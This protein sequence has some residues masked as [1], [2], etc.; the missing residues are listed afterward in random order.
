MS[1]IRNLIMAIIIIA[2]VSGASPVPQVFAESNVTI[3]LGSTKQIF[4]SEYSGSSRKWFSSNPEVVSIVDYEPNGRSCTIRGESIGKAV[5]TVFVSYNE[6]VPQWIELEDGKGYWNTGSIKNAK[7]FTYN[8]MVEE[9]GLKSVTEVHIREQQ[10]MIKGESRVF[11]AGLTPRLTSDQ[12][13]AWKSSNTKVAT[14]DASGRVKAVDEGTATITVTALKGNKSDSCLLNVTSLS[15]YT[16]IS[17]KKQLDII[18]KNPSGRFYLTKDI[19]FTD[20]DFKSGG[21]YY[22]AGKG[23]APIE[24]FTGVFNGNGHVIKNLRISASGEEEQNTG[25][26]A[27]N[28]G[29]VSNL[30]FTGGSITSKVPNSRL[31]MITGFNP[32][33]GII[34]N[35]YNTGK[36][37]SVSICGGIAGKND[38]KILDCYN[39]GSIDAN[40]NED[41]SAGGIAGSSGQGRDAWIIDC[42]NKGTIS[43][44]GIDYINVGGI[45]GKNDLSLLIRCR[46]TGSVTAQAETAHYLNQGANAGGIAGLSTGGIIRQC[47]NN[48]GITGKKCTYAGGIT[49][50]VNFINNTIIEDSY[51]TG[52]V[53]STNGETGGAG[54]IL[55]CT[56]YNAFYGGFANNN[57]INCYNTGKIVSGFDRTGGI[58][59]AMLCNAD[60]T[61]TYINDCY[62]LNNTA[63]GAGLIWKTAGKAVTYSRSAAEMKKQA[64]FSTFDFKNTWIIDAASGYPYPQLRANRQAA[65]GK[66]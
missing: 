56:V 47:F 11:T 30:G 12:R 16:P 19:V 27:V 55:G 48:A 4:Y 22:N 51:N 33:E 6:A 32:E 31:G 37:S 21:A 39:T 52:N 61:G 50:T 59:G 28:K 18:R 3:A 17:D 42:L 41:L 13:V 26:F 10:D 57:F 65:A 9:D 54:G 5:V 20:A 49:G 36:I 34:Q 40:G 44:K 62:F 15:K 35:C 53:S 7:T 43:G 2:L 29:Q 66:K 25:F 46:N 8:V 64:G 58:V 45:I 24:E 1:R 38:G 23:W 60:T 14:V 63:K